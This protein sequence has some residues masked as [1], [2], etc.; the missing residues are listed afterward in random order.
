VLWEPRAA[1]PKWNTVFGDKLRP[2][3]CAALKYPTA[4]GFQTAWPA[5]RIGKAFTTQIS[6]GVDI[7]ERRLNSAQFGGYLE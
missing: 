4:K 6:A 7:P 1:Y 2:V 5:S 3:Q